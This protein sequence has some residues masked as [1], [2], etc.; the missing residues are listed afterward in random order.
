[1]FQLCNRSIFS[2]IYM[3]I[4]F[5]FFDFFEKVWPK[6]A[7]DESGFG[8]GV[9][10][11]CFTAIRTR[12]SRSTGNIIPYVHKPPVSA[13]ARQETATWNRL[14]VAGA[15]YYALQVVASL[16][17]SNSRH[18]PW[19]RTLANRNLV[20]GQVKMDN[21]VTN[22]IWSGIDQHFQNKRCSLWL[23]IEACHLLWYYL[24][25]SNSHL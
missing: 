19:Y 5:F 2:N 3:L 21:N 12:R 10:G 6:Q 7:H 15:Q 16:R 4:F 25:K 24:F 20:I 9:S 22:L 1:M 8:M 23:L 14:G 11:K 17:R 13:S 18:H